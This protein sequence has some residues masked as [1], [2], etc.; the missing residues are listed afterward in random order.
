[1]RI[2]L[3]G[4]FGSGNLG[5]DGSLEAMINFLR[6]E[7]PNAELVCICEGPVEIEKSFKISAIPIRYNVIRQ[8]IIGHIPLSQTV[9]SLVYALRVAGKFDV[10]ISPGTGLLDDFTE[11]PWG[12]PAILATWCAGARVRGTKTAFVSVG[13]GPIVHPLSRWLFKAAARMVHYRSYRD[14]ESKEFLRS[15]GMGVDDDPVFPDLAFGLPSPSTPSPA[16]PIAVGVGVM[17]YRGWRGDDGQGAGIYET[18]IRNLVQFIKWLLDKGF[19]VRMLIGDQSD[20]PALRD[21][22]A[23]LALAHPHYQR[24]AVTYAERTTSLNDVMQQMAHTDIV[25]ATRFHNIVCALM[26]KKP[27]I[28]VG[29]S[30][31]FDVLME[32]MGLGQFCHH[33]ERLDVNL[34]TKHVE[35]L[36][37]NKEL[38]RR[39]LDKVVAEYR[40]RL[41]D[42]ETSLKRSLLE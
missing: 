38:Y 3:L 21:V 9:L 37:A 10:I 23:A 1:M 33:I 13:A 35:E 14:S 4:N 11:R 40:Q 18:Y 30:R 39:M 12:M 22:L 15:I 28:S 26:M 42:Q 27:C 32:D 31:K 29:Y 5:N 8:N 2:G 6:K 36:V 7:A 17:Q 16:K 41:S 34:L 24:S 19:R 25:V 20:E